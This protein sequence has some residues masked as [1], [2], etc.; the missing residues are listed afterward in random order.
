MILMGSCQLDIFYDAIYRFCKI[1]MGEKKEEKKN[2]QTQGTKYLTVPQ[3]I[4]LKKKLFLLTAL[5][6]LTLQKTPKKPTLHLEVVFRKLGK[7]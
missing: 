7:Q 6:S 2:N 3:G 4:G 1:D 5:C